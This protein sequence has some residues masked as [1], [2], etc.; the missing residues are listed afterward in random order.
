MFELIKAGGLLMIPILACSVVATAII[1]E[2]FWTLKSS[3]VVPPNLVAQIWEWVKSD[4]LDDARIKAIYDSSPVGRVLASGLVNRNHSREVM[5]ESI[6]DIG[7]HVAHELERFVG[8]LGTIASISPLLG[9]LGTVLGMITVFTVITTSGVGDP[10]EL[11][12]G[13]SQALITTA[14]GL[15][16]AIPSIIFNRFFLAKVENLVVNMEE[17]ALKLV[18]VIHGEREAGTQ[19]KGKAK[20]KRAK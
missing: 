7:R 15:T 4:Q 14:A 16:V 9:L 13:I 12:G 1:L 5:K 8:V 2:R 17:E 19:L 3:R 6:Q 20:G 10:G 18:E 11:A